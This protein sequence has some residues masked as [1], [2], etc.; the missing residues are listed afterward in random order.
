MKP[1]FSYMSEIMD[2]SNKNEKFVL[3][4]IGACDGF[5]SQLICSL[6]RIYTNKFIMHSF[7]PV[8]TLFASWQT[9]CK[10]HLEHINFFNKAVGNINGNVS[11]NVSSG[12]DYYGSSSLR[13]PAVVLSSFPEMKFHKTSV[14]SITLDTHCAQTNLKKIDFIWMDVQGAERDVFDGAK[15]ILKKTRYIYTEFANTND[16]EGQFNLDQLLNQLGANWKVVEN[17]G[18]DVLLKNTDIE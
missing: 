15:N 7:E 2:G 9:W 14:E 8:K 1:I 4:E 3:I 16:Y 12:K 18:G 17:Y 6:L 5:H 10:M 11:F 13:T